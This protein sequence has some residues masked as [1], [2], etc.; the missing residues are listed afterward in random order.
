VLGPSV[1]ERAQPR[2]ET[3]GDDHG[4]HGAHRIVAP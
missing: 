3:P 2:A 1:G 4:F